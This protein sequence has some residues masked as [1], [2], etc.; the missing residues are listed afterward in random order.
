ME[1][2]YSTNLPQQA[3]TPQQ[4]KENE[5]LAA[6]H[7]GL[8]MTELMSIAGNTVADWLIGHYSPQHPVLIISGCG[9]NAGDGFVVASQLMA[10][11]FDV[12]VWPLMSVSRLSGDAKHMMQTY[13]DNNGKMVSKPSL[14]RY[15]IIVDALFGIG[16]D[17]PLSDELRA[18]I[19]RINNAKAMRIAIDVPSGVN[20]LTGQVY[21]DAFA[22][23]HTITFIGLKQGLLTGKA[24][25]QCGHLWFA[26]LGVDKAFAHIC[27]THTKR[28]TYDDMMAKR[29]RRTPSSH[30]G[31]A[32]HVL[33]VAG[34]LGMAGAARLCAEAALRC[35]AG[36][37]SVATHPDNVNAVLQG[38]YELMVHGVVD[39]EQ[40]QPLV[41]KADVIVIGPGLGQSDWART[42]LK[43]VLNQGQQKHKVLDADALNLVAKQQMAL[44]RTVITPHPKE[45]ARLLSCTVQ[46]IESNRYE[47]VKTLAK[48]LKVTALLKGPGTIV[49]HEQNTFINSSG[50]EV[51][52]SAGMGDVLSGIIASFLAQ[53]LDLRDA[54]CLGAFIHGLAAEQAA[55]EGG[56]GLLASD[57]FPILRSLVG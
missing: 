23:H 29:V 26:G 38:R 48:Q 40:L 41:D 4:L 19:A 6:K 42:L 10:A 12:E 24:K 8:S 11:G 25:Q 18:D 15:D 2:K 1:P 20:A 49:Y 32:G 52:A 30:K 50:S 44:T 5:P 7:C 56:K 57:L 51:L 37:V 46:N 34:G 47:A 13:Q 54:T 53:G 31:S 28:L 27:H 45:A 21:D 9:N 39:G 35:G 3:F 22:A 43:S 33:V 14:N 55:K 17:R 36:L 16:L